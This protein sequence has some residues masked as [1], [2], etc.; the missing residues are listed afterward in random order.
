M[1]FLQV[2]NALNHILLELSSHPE[3]QEKLYRELVNCYPNDHV[4]CEEVA[5]SDYLNA[6]VD[7]SLR[8]HVSLPRLLRI[9][10]EDCDLGRF[11]VRVL[12]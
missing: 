1:S 9:A 11:Q 7:E 8:L 2:S 5:K 10:V 12:I 4:P 6:V 3:V